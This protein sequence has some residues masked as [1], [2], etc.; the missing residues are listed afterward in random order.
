MALGLIE[1][2]GFTTAVVVGDAVAKAG[3]VRIVALDRNKPAAGDA[4]KVPLVMMVKFE[5]GVA[6]V[7]AA[8]EAGVAEAKKRD[9]YITSYVIT[10]PEDSTMELAKINALGRDKLNAPRI[11]RLKIENLYFRYKR[12][13]HPIDG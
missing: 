5:G 2:F 1:V 4:A 6:E 10:R 9:L 8:L 3:N 11:S 12:Y 13:I 7:E